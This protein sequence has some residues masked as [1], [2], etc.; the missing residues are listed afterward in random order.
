M[1]AVDLIGLNSIPTYPYLTADKEYIKKWK[2]IIDSDKLKVG[3][4]WAGNIVYEEELWRTLP[5]D[6]LFESVSFDEVQLYSLQRDDN[7]VALPSHIID[8]SP[9]LKT[10]E[11]TAGAMMNLDLIISSC[12]SIPHL[13]A[14]LGIETWVIVPTLEYY[15]WSYPWYDV[16]KVYR[17]RKFR[18]WDLPLSE[19]HKDLERRLHEVE[20][21]MRGQSD[22]W[23]PQ[24]GHTGELQP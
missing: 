9:E 16:V 22:G 19:V 12:T 5:T 8:L 2:G 23:L 11:D 18:E 14:A 15:S 7:M 3:I 6:A 24:C 4:R 20:C 1:N 13:S 17:Q 21:R 10:W